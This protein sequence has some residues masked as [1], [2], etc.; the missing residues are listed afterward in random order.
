M[1]ASRTAV[2]PETAQG[3]VITADLRAALEPRLI[4]DLLGQFGLSDLDIAIATA[5]N[6]RTVRR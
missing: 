4:T 6:P 5:T 2:P 1:A 3:A